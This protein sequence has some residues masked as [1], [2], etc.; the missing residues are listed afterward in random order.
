MRVMIAIV[1]GVIIEAP[2]PWTTRA[3]ISIS[4]ELVSP[5]HSDARVKTVSPVM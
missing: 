1:C 4:T 3:T 2:S 5:H